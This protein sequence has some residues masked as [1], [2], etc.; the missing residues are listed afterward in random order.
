MIIQNIWQIE[1]LV[2]EKNDTIIYNVSPIIN[3][4]NKDELINELTNKKWVMKVIDNYLREIKMIENFSIY[5]IPF[6]IKM[7]SDKKFRS[8]I[9]YESGWYVME[10]YDCNLRTNFLFGKNKI[11]LLV[12]NIISFIECIHINHKIVHGDIKA[13]NILIKFD[14]N[15]NPFKLID[16]ESLCHPEKIKCIDENKDGYYYYGLGCYS[17]KPFMSYRMDLESF[18]IILWSLTLS[19]ENFYKF[20]WQSEAFHKYENY[21]N[22][23]IY[24][25]LNQL[26]KNT[27]ED[28]NETIK[29]YFEIVSELDWYEL[30]PKP[31]IYTKIKDL[32]N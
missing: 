19:I 23:N 24:E 9:D 25:Y 31:Y 30:N 3:N 5:N 6:C 27:P 1:S 14:D 12:L 17:D 20:Y 26:R 28:K 11:K 18:G 4:L 10:K 13:D 15:E 2:E 32:F 21:S 29:K 7:P 8:G 16:F 22:G